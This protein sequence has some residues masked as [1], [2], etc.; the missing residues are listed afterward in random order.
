MKE[1][2]YEAQ[3]T[4]YASPQPEPVEP[5]TRTYTDNRFAMNMAH[6]DLFNQNPSEY[7]SRLLRIE[8]FQ[9]KEQTTR[10]ESM[11]RNPNQKTILD[12]T[13]LA[14]RLVSLNH[15]KNTTPTGHAES[16]MEDA[17]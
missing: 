13:S 6:L 17:D 1:F 7:S 4:G 9:T 8:D 14:H 3:S 16:A 2:P 11:R 5:S 12:D 15:A 10:P